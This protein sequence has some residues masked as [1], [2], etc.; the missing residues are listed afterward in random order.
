MRPRGSAMA[1]QSSFLSGGGDL[2][3]GDHEQLALQE[4]LHSIIACPVSFVKGFPTSNHIRY[5]AP[6]GLLVRRGSPVQ[7]H[8]DPDRWQGVSGGCSWGAGFHRWILAWDPGLGHVKRFDAPRGDVRLGGTCQSPKNLATPGEMWYNRI[9]RRS[10]VPVVGMP[11]RPA[12]D[13]CWARGAT[14]AQVT[15]NHQVPGSNP[16]GPIGAGTLER[17]DVLTF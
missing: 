9:N 15:H 16:G 8:G 3:P 11:R 4:G 1:K 12:W 6:G 2:T 7:R 5:S 10:H 14:A 13:L 17:S